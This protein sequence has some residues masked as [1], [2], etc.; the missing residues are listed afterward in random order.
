MKINL[1]ELKDHGRV[2]GEKERIKDNQLKDVMDAYRKCAEEN[3]SL[4]KRLESL[5]N[6]ETTLYENLRNIERELSMAKAENAALVNKQTLHMEEIGTLEQHVESLNRELELS[7]NQLGNIQQVNSRI[8]NDH[9]TANTVVSAL[10][11]NNNDIIRKL[12]AQ[13]VQ[14]VRLNENLPYR[15][16]YYQDEVV[17]LKQENTQLKSVLDAK[18][19]QIM[20]LENVLIQEREKQFLQ[21]RK[22][23]QLEQE[24]SILASSSAFAKVE[25]CLSVLKF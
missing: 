16:K 20:S 9:R 19:N 11:S 10:E 2:A 8:I 25:S 4:K 21:H 7:H 14:S 23:V 3:D 24:N 22:L 15:Q 18:S 6:I 13:E 1:N 12:T 5:K 17:A